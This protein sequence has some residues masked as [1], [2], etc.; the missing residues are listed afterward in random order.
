M[1]MKKKLR[2]GL[3][4]KEVVKR[5]SSVLTSI[6]R[7][8]RSYYEN[9]FKE[10]KGNI[11]STWRAIST[12]LGAKQ[13]SHNKIKISKDGYTPATDLET[14]TEFN[15]FFS[16][17]GAHLAR[18]IPETQTYVTTY[19]SRSYPNSLLLSPVSPTDV[20]SII[21]SLKTKAGNISEIPSMVHRR[22]SHAL[23][24]SIAL[25]FNKSLECH[26]FPDIL[27]KARVTPVHK[28]GNTADINNYRPISNLPI[29]SKLFF[30]FLQ[31]ALLQSCK[32]QYTKSLSVWLPLPKEYQ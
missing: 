30:F 6:I 12:I 24:P 5:Y 4:G 19:L 29:L 22:A 3:V 21:H 26:T 7:A 8:K 15:S 11:K 16:S 14:A 27:K 31:T 18:K 32:I 13:H 23:A 17:F 20:V 1:N 28:G 25:L 2:I 10:A 9:R